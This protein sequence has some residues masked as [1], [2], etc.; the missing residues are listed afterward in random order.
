MLLKEIIENLRVEKGK[1]YIDATIGGAGHAVEILKSGG[2]VLGI[3]C[4]QEAIEYVRGTWKIENRRWK[5]NEDNLSLVRGNFRDIDKIAYA[6]GFDKVAGIVFDLGV[7][8]HQLDEGERGFSFLREGPLDM[9]MDQ[10]LS[11]C[12][13]DLINVLT[14]GELYELF[15]KLGEENNAR[16]VS[17][18]IISARRIKPIKTTQDLV[19]IIKEVKPNL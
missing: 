18:H 4:D 8:S 2:I 9:R 11:I 6:N 12:A 16:E 7:S 1:K 15:S 17:R 14:K 5:I 19:K 13:K 10:D 3:D